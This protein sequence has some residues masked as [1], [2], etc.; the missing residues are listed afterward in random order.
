MKNIITIIC[1]FCGNSIEYHDVY[2]FQLKG[3]ARCL[4]CKRYFAIREAIMMNGISNIRKD[5]YE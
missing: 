1:P 4:N 3:D 5:Y 2:E